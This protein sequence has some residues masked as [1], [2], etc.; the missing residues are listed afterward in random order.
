M[1]RTRS[2]ADSTALHRRSLLAVTGAVALSA[3]AGYA[4]RS[5]GGQAVAADAGADGTVLTSSRQAP[6][7]PLAP[8]TR[9]T[10]VA[11]MS[12]PRGGRAAGYRRL[13]E[14]PGWERVV[15]GEL[16]GARSGREDRRTT[17]AAFVQL[18]DLHVIDA[19]H[20][21]RLEYLRSADVHAWR[22]H[23]A[24]TVHGAVSS[25]SGSTPCAAP[26][27]PAPRCTSR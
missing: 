27:S 26:P 10:T 5:G 7:A 2:V 8:Y 21:L 6:A 11:G 20:P 1:P 18:T 14:G 16:A 24:L 9:G 12:V 22:P 3:G 17:L 13:D 19:Q 23:E 4:L 25:S 15:R